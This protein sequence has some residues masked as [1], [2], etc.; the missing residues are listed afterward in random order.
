M[1]RQGATVYRVKLPCCR[2]GLHLQVPFVIRVGMQFGHQLAV[3]AWREP[4]DG[5]FDFGDRGHE[6]TLSNGAEQFNPGE[7]VMR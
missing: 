1:F 6:R 5:F 7:I 2:I 3:F 4:R